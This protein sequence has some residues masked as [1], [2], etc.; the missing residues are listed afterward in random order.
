MKVGRTQYSILYVHIFVT[1]LNHLRFFFL[2]F[3]CLV[4][5]TNY[6]N[7]WEKKLPADWDEND[8]VDFLYSLRN[9]LG[10]PCEYFASFNLPNPKGNS[11]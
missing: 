6:G 8:T 2:S 10:I 9:K 7:T 1:L 3:V 5:N 4:S 11:I